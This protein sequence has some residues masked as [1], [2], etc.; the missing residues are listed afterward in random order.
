MLPVMTEVYGN[1]PASIIS[2]R[3]RGRSW[4]RAARR[5]RRCLGAKAEEIV[6]TSGGTEADN[7]AIFGVARGGHVD[8]HHRRASGRAG[9]RRA[10]GSVTLVPV[11]GRGMVDPD[12]IRRAL[13]PDTKLI[14]VMHAN[15]ETR[16]DPADRGD[17]A[18]RARG[19]R[20]VAFR[21][22]AGGGKDSGERGELGVDLYSISGHKIYAP[23]GVG[24]LYV[25]KGTELAA[26]AVRR[27]PRAR[28]ARGHGECRRARWRLGARREWIVEHGAARI[29]A[30]GAL[31]AIGWSRAFST[32][33]RIRT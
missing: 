17:R 19:R 28:A 26:D 29:A 11:D 4:T 14:S 31:C 15:N 7:L 2:A 33:F 21:R 23:K 32:A 1:A 5:W 9:A 22:R 24:A 20:R 8:H 13:R 30:R 3:P 10:A 6:F 27:S 25:R 18:H 12:A 16:H